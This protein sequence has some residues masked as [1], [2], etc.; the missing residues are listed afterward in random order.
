VVVAL[1]VGASWGPSS[2]PALA[3]SALLLPY[4]VSEVWSSAVRFIRVDRGYVVREKDPGN[5]YILFDLGEGGKTYKGALELIRATDQDGR[6]ATRAALSLP[7]LPRHYEAMLLDKL[8]AK[9]REERGSPP[10]PPPPPPRQPPDR[11]D[12]APPPRPPS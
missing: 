6:D 10:P 11:R 4:P 3:R 1:V 7:D 9:V 5:G 8:A 2:G 12:A